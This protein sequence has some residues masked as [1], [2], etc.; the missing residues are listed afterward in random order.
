[1]YDFEAL[2]R[3]VFTEQRMKELEAH[4]ERRRKELDEG[5]KYARMIYD[6]NL[7]KIYKSSPDLDRHVIKLEELEGMY[8]HD[9][10]ILKK[11]KEILKE[12]VALL[13]PEERKAYHAWK[14]S[15]FIM[16]REIAPVIAACLEH[17]VTEKGWQRETICAI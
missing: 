16:H 17:V 14:Q 8:K 5:N 15:G 10:Y 13:Y 1:M 3:Y 9:R 7:G 4:Y 11:D 6:S 12:A 2:T